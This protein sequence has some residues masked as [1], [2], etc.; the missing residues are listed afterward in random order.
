VAAIPARSSISS[1]I[2]GRAVGTRYDNPGM[3]EQSDQ[4]LQMGRFCGVCRASLEGR[5]PHTEVC[6][7]RCRIERSR[8]RRLMVGKYRGPW[9]SLADNNRRSPMQRSG[10]PPVA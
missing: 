10:G 8:I 1:T 7:P 6:R 3:T 2:V 5:D 9:P 4:Q